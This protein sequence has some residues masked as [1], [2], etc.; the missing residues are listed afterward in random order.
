MHSCILKTMKNFN[1]L[2]TISLFAIVLSCVSTQSTIKNIDNKAIKPALVNKHF[3]LAEKS[4]D[5]KYGYNKDYPI[6]VGFENET[7]SLKNITYFFNAL[8]GPQGEKITFNKSGDCCPFPTKRSS[9]GAGTLLIYDVSFEG[10]SEKKTLYF[11][12]FEKG[13]I[14]C[15]TGFSIKKQDGL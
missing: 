10:K 15:P 4:T 1:F 5:S 3:V 12:V 13:K 11:N 6:N 14:L 2:L 9:M 7:F 8:A